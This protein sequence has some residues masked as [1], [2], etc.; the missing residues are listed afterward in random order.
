MTGGT[1]TKIQVGVNGFTGTMLR[2]DTPLAADAGIYR[3]TDTSVTPNEFMDLN[4][5]SSKGHSFN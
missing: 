3:C 2:F 5:T 1:L 4:I